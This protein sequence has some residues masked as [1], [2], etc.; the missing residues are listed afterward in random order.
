MTMK[1]LLSRLV[2]CA[3]LGGTTRTRRNRKTDASNADALGPSLDL[4][5]P[6]TIGSK[7]SRRGPPAL[8]LNKKVSW[9]TAQLARLDRSLQ[10]VNEAANSE[11]G[12]AGSP[13]ALEAGSG[14][15][16][17]RRPSLVQVFLQVPLRAH[18]GI[19]RLSHHSSIITTHVEQEAENMDAG[20]LEVARYARRSSCAV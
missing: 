8:V 7:A 4:F 15:P 6:P 9:F 3:G 13:R 10:T 12:T 18:L 1:P 11:C 17:S 2:P 14:P 19:P 5:R 20:P 16:S